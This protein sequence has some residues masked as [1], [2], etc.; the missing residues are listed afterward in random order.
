MAEP[1]WHDLGPVADLQT[2]Q[3][4]Q[5]AVGRTRIA[6]TWQSGQ[7]GAI[8]GACNHVGGPLG[9]GTLD[10]EYVVCPWHHWKYHCRTGLGEPGYEAES[11]PR[12]DLEVR[13]DHQ[14][15]LVLGA[16]VGASP[17]SLRSEAKRA[18]PRHL[19]VVVVGAGLEVGTVL[20]H[21]HGH[22]QSR[23]TLILGGPSSRG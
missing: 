9:E 12:F 17:G 5:I 3:L 7:F 14:D 19:A 13:G 16:R 23:S 2:K 4:Q 22:H 11:L 15:L 20:S 21:G 10:G 8:S 18:E 6:L 1:Q